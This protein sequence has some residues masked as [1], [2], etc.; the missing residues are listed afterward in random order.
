MNIIR[1][2]HNKICAV[3]WNIGFIEK[4]ISR[5]LEGESYQIKFLQHNYHDRWFADPWLLNVDD[6]KIKCLVEEKKF[7]I[8]QNGYI[9]ILTINRHTFRLEERKTILKLNSHLSFPAILRED[10][11]V[12]IYPENGAGEGLGLYRIKQDGTCDHIRNLSQ[13]SLADA[14]ITDVF[15]EKM[16][17]ATKQP[18]QN[19]KTLLQ[20]RCDHKGRYKLADEIHFEENI[21]RNAGNWFRIGDHV[22]RPAQD[23]NGGYGKAVILQEALR[24]DEGDFSFR[25]VVRLTSTDEKLNLGLHTFN[26]IGDL[27]VTDA[28]GYKNPFWLVKTSQ[29]IFNVLSGIKQ[30]IK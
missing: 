23:C 6:D 28:Y 13:E 20:Y 14:V 22:Y 12:F 11:A 15:G 26:Y 24:S 10:E 18:N 21:A 17:F 2:V 25:N 7:G 30:Y 9:S 4:P 27:I 16:M 5:L 1:K 29:L 8:N 19:G 3:K